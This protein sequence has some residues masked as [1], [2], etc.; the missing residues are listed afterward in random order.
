MTVDAALFHDLFP[1]E[2]SKKLLIQFGI[3]WLHSLKLTAR[4]WKLI[5]GRR[6]FPFIPFGMLVFSGVKCEASARLS[7]LLFEGCRGIAVRGFAN[8]AAV[9]VLGVGGKWRED[10]AVGVPIKEVQ[11]HL[12]SIGISRTWIFSMNWIFGAFAFHSRQ[13]RNMVVWLNQFAVVWNIKDMETLYL[14]EIPRFIVTAH[15]LESSWYGY[16]I[17]YH[18]KLDLMI[19]LVGHRQHLSSL[20]V[21]WLSPAMY[22][23]HWYIILP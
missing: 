7:F 8:W 23:I 3:I 13:W 14:L 12:A 9:E 16:E 21:C 22:N 17:N 5:V 2:T 20:N 6:S 1:N 15:G 4:P 10:V 18:Q 19:P 11:V